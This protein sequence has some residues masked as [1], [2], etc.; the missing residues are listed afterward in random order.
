[1]LFRP[2]EAPGERATLSVTGL[3]PG[4]RV[5]GPRPLRVQVNAGPPQVFTFADERWATVAVTLPELEP[6]ERGFLVEFDVGE[7][8]NLERLGLDPEP[9][10][11]GFR[12]LAFTLA[13]AA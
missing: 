8:I 9:R 2:A 10:D 7:V 5:A 13:Q 1:M 3:M 4:V 6:D 11:L 12:L